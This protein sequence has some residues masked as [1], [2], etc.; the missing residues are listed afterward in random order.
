MVR[1]S[2]ML[3]ACCFVLATLSSC[4]RAPQQ[5]LEAV[6]KPRNKALRLAAMNNLRQIAL[7]MIMYE[8][9]RG[10]YPHSRWRRSAEEPGLSW[11]VA[12]LPYLGEGNLY[13][14]FK[15]DEPWDSPHNIKLIDRMPALFNRP[16]TVGDGTT[17]YMVF[18]GEGAPLGEHPLAGPSRQQIADGV[19][20]TI[21]I[22]QAG[23]DVAV[24]WTK[25]QDLPFD[26][27]NPMAALG[28]VSSGGFCVAFFDGSVRVIDPDMDAGEFK[29]MITHNGGEPVSGGQF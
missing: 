5:A 18:V 15:L 6:S 2:L 28:A 29:A 24:P 25:P 4:G 7:A 27:E 1:F 14:Q 21:A 13:R 17:S 20:N 12:L 11:R 23:P 16:K 10:R 26:P 22:V 9:D 3:T 8:N 19:A